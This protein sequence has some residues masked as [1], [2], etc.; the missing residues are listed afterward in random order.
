[1]DPES[2]F[3]KERRKSWARL[4][5]EILEVD[6]LLCP[7]CRVELKIVSAITDPAV[8]DPILRHVE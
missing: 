1:V 4:L 5:R 2:G 7:R 6:P 8:V 3:A